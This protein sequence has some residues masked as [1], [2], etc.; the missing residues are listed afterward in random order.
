[1]SDNM[2][3]GWDNKFLPMEDRL[4]AAKREIDALWST[5]HDIAQ[6]NVTKDI[7]DVQQMAIR[8]ITEGSTLS[9]CGLIIAEPSSP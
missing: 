1:M 8:Q 9:K 7:R 3:Y 4:D 2:F 5:L 6:F